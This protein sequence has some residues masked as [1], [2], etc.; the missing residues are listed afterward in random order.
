MDL[1]ALYSEEEAK[2]DFLVCDFGN[3]V[4]YLHKAPRNITKRLTALLPNALDVKG[5]PGMPSNTLK[6]GNEHITQLFPAVD[7][8]DP[9]V[10]EPGPCGSPQASWEDVGH[11]LC[12]FASHLDQP[13]ESLKVFS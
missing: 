11:D 7:L 5:L 4:M 6:V 13:I 3:G 2:D 9:L 8:P 10:G 1:A 12:M